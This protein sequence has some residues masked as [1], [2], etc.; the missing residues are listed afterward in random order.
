[1]IWWG[2]VANIYIVLYVYTWIHKHIKVWHNPLQLIWSYESPKL[3]N[4]LVH[5]SPFLDLTDHF[6]I[7]FFSL[8]L[9]HCMLLVFLL[10]NLL[11]SLASL[12]VHL[13]SPILDAV[14]PLILYSS[15]YLNHSIAG[16]S[17]VSSINISDPSKP[18]SVELLQS[19]TWVL[20][21][22]FLCRQL[23]LQSSIPVK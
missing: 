7:L 3:L 14:S 20:L 2:K 17:Q 22:T 13:Q 5:F 8:L 23:D 4:P 16:E 12:P 21:D 10:N 6:K 9:L 18:L 1:M 11:T 15:A 19:E